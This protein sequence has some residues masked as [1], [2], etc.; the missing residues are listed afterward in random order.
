MNLNFQ[1]DCLVETSRQMYESEQQQQQQHQQ[2]L[3]VFII[4]NINISW[5]GGL[6][7]ALLSFY[8]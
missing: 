4:I 6:K 8:K 2:P 1:R 5:Q 3:F 7:Q